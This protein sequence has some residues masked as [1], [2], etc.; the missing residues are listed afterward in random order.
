MRKR[1]GIARAMVLDPEILFCD[2][3]SAGLDPITSAE[4]DALIL[5]LKRLFDMTVVVVTHELASIEAIA[6]SLIMV[7]GGKVLAEGPAAQVRAMGHPEVDA[8]F[9]RM[10]ELRAGSRKTAAGLLGL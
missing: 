4:L 5:N 6:D 2:E 8:F 9:A 1:A 3:P 10:G 7:G